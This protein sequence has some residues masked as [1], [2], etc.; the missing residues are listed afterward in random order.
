MAKAYPDPPKLERMISGPPLM[1]PYPGDEKRDP[2]AP[3]VWAKLKM[4]LLGSRSVE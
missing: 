1:R 2:S 3:T 4:R